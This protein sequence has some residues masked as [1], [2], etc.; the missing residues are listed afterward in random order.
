MSDRFS[1][2]FSIGMIVFSL[3]FNSQCK[4]KE[5]EVEQ[6][7]EPAPVAP[8]P[9]PLVKTGSVTAISTT[10]A[11][12]GGE[13]TSEGNRIV[14]AVGV[15][16]DT[17]PAP[18][19]LRPHTVDGAGIG[20]YQSNITPL[21]QN[22]TYYVRAYA[23]NLQGPAYGAEVSFKT[24]AAWQKVIGGEN[25]SDRFNQLIA[26]DSRMLLATK[27]GVA[28]STQGTDWTA[29]SS[30]PSAAEVSQICREGNTLVASVLADGIYRSPDLGITWQ[31]VKTNNYPGVL[32]VKGSTLFAFYDN[33][34]YR[35]DNSGL[36][37]IPVANAPVAW[38]YG[39][40]HITGNTL[41]VSTGTNVV[42]FSPDL[43]NTWTPSNGFNPNDWVISFYED[44]S[45]IF[46]C[47]S[48]GLYV[49]SDQGKTWVKASASLPT[50]GSAMQMIRANGS[51]YVMLNNGVW[52][53]ADAN[54]WQKMESQLPLTSPV[55]S[56]AFYKGF[57][58]ASMLDGEV[59]RIALN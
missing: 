2:L 55:T 54:A 40:M 48:G 45:K 20:K 50:Q 32:A 22:T 37:W 5:K 35:S 23:S 18:T 24:A 29:L 10:S 17:Q 15:C 59:W 38:S 49:T 9:L 28:A 21:Q 4:K 46:A 34:L 30:F 8:S 56:F 53:S 6:E 25:F 47:T 7:P 39:P 19:L 1:R 43:G 27:F 16:W 52:R 41:L 58:Y 13:I 14:T 36:N 44:G 31:K 42:F 11:L 51:F 57:L 26:L 3:A 12:C 33:G